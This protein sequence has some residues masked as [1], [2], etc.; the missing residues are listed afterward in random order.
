MYIL[1]ILLSYLL[2]C[3]N[4][5]YYIAKLRGVDM[6]KGSGNL[7]T[8]NAVILM[9][10]GSGVLAF[11]HDAGK[12]V[13]AVALAKWLLPGQHLAECVAGVCCV[14]GHIFPFYLGFKGGKGFASYL[15][16]TLMLNW[17]LALIIAAA[18]ILLTLITDYL[19]VGTVTTVVSVPVALGFVCKSILPPLVLLIATGVILWKHRE[20]YVRIYKGTEIGLRSTSRG[21]HR[22]K[23]E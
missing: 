2:G 11:L 18:V 7:G 17:K 10:W 14:L 4:M 1:L 9:G 16:M 20:N 13:L 12:A 19:V 6:T 22:Q 21:E 15:G 23:K 8:S 3:S 5:T